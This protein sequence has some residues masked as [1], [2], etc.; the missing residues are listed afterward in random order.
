MSSYSESVDQIAGL[1]SY[2]NTNR[3]MFLIAGYKEAQVRANLI[4]PF[5]M[6]LGWDVH[7]TKRVA[8]QYMPV[9]VEPSL[10]DEG[11]RKAPDYA[12]RVGRETKF[13]GEA[14]KVGVSIKTDPGPAYQL[15]RYAWSAKLP[16][17]LLTD[18]EEL[19]VYDCRTRPSEKDK[20]ATGRIR[21]YSVDEY[22]DRWR[23]IWDILSYDAVI[24]G[25]FDQFA[26]SARGRRG[27]S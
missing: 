1:V 2:F 18:F 21:Y 26:E 27:A 20:A 22:A 6:A 5:F 15:R 9:V 13:F 23:E 17:S 16:I 14:K 8:P 7:N 11:Q 10:D 3:Q 25:S 19:S 12:F 24:G 4:D